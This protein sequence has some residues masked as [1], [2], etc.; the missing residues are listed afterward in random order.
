MNLILPPPVAV[1]EPAQPAVL[2]A[3]QVAFLLRCSEDTFRNKRRRLEAAGFPRKLP[4]CARWSRAAVLR[5]IETNGE[6]YLPADLDGRPDA[7]GL[8][9]LEARYAS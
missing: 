5:W 1:H 9:A 7:P 3:G 4:G 6:T 2:T 8:N